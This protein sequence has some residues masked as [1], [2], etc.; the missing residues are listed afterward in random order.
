MLFTNACLKTQDSSVN[1]RESTKT[2]K[3]SKKRETPWLHV[4]TGTIA[5]VVSSHHIA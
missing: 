5:V 3:N 1:A 4:T 2:H